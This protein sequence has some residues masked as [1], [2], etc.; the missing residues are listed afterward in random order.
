MPPPFGINDISADTRI[1]ERTLEINGVDQDV[2]R[3]ISKE[4]G[5]SPATFFHAIYGLILAALGRTD[6]VVFGTVMSG[7]QVGDFDYHD[8]VGLFINTIPIRINI[9]NLSIAQFFLTVQDLLIAVT[10]HEQTSLSDIQKQLRLEGDDPLFTSL[11]N[12]RHA[13]E[14]VEAENGAGTGIEIVGTNERTNYPLSFGVSDLGDRFEISIKSDSRVASDK[15]KSYAA[16][17]V[18]EFIRLFQL[19]TS[20]PAMTAILPVPLEELIKPDQLSEIGPAYEEVAEL[21]FCAANYDIVQRFEDSVSRAADKNAIIISGR[22]LTF[23]QL[24]E[25]SSAIAT[26]LKKLGVMSGDRV[27]IL[28]NRHE[29]IPINILA[30]LKLGATYVPVDTKMPAS[31]INFICANAGVKV[32]LTRLEFQ[33]LLDNSSDAAVVLTDSSDTEIVLQNSEETHSFVPEKCGDLGAYIIYT[34][35]STGKPKGVLTTRSNLNYFSFVFQDQ[36]SLLHVEQDDCWLWNSAHTFDASIKGLVCLANGM[37]LVMP[38]D[39]EVGDVDA[40]VGLIKKHD[41]EVFNSLPHV[42]EQVLDGIREDESLTLNFIVSG[43]QV[44]NKLWS[45][46][47]EYSSERNLV[48]INAYGP[49]E[50]T[51]N[52]AFAVITSQNPP[53]IGTPVQGTRCRVIDNEGRTVAK[54]IRGELV[55]FGPGVC[56]GYLDSVEASSASF[57]FNKGRFA[58]YKTGDI[59]SFNNDGYLTFHGRADR[60]VKVRGYRIELT[61]IEL[62][63][64]E[65]TEIIE[66]FVDV[67]QLAEGQRLIVAYI[68]VEKTYQFNRQVIEAHVTKMIPDYMLPNR[69]VTVEKLPRTTTGKVDSRLLRTMG[70]ES[71][72][73][74]SSEVQKVGTVE[75]ELLLVWKEVLGLNSISYNDDFIELGGDSILSMQLVAKAKRKGISITVRDVF[76]NRTIA[77]LAQIGSEVKVNQAYQKK[78]EGGQILLPVQRD[79]LALNS[80][81]DNQFN[82]SVLLK[83]SVNISKSVLA[84]IVTTLIRRHDGLRQKFIKPATGDWESNYHIFTRPDLDQAMEYIDLEGKTNKE[85]ETAIYSIGTRAQGAMDIHNGPMFKAVYFSTGKLAQDR[86]LLI[87]HHLVVD[88]VSWRILIQDIQDYYQISREGGAIKPDPKTCSYQLWAQQLKE[89]VAEGKF[90]DEEKVWEKYLALNVDGIASD[91]APAQVTE[92]SNLQSLSFKLDATSTRALISRGAEFYKAEAHELLIAALVHAIQTLKSFMN[93]R[94]L[95]EGHGRECSIVPSDLSETVGWFTTRYPLTITL[96]DNNLT[97]TVNTAKQACRSIPNGGTGFAALRA[98][99]TDISEAISSAYESCQL[100]FNYLGQFDQFFKDSALLSLDSAQYGSDVG[101]HIQVLQDLNLD[102]IIIDGELDINLRFCPKRYAQEDISTLGNEFVAAL[103]GIVDL[104]TDQEKSMPANISAYISMEELTKICR[105][106]TSDQSLPAVFCTPPISGASLVYGALAEQLKEQMCLYGLQLP[107]LYSDASCDSVENVAAI[108]V[109]IVQFYQESGP[110]RIIGW[111]S[112]GTLAYELARQLKNTGN[113]I[114]FLTILDQP[115]RAPG[116]QFHLYCNDPLFK[117]EGLYKHDLKLDWDAVKLMQQPDAINYIA[118]EIVS[119]GLKP[120]G[121]EDKTIVR[122]LQA[123]VSFPVAMDRYDHPNSDLNINLIRAEQ[124]EDNGKSDLGWREI[125]S[126]QVNIVLSD[127]EHM[128]MV[129]EKHAKCLAKNILRSVVRTTSCVS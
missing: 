57:T 33:H 60:Q 107:S 32:V 67:Q 43:D 109:S 106:L 108:Y 48:A 34:S 23:L 100:Q 76:E 18:S 69:Y 118:S 104:I 113:E 19:D 98:Y 65:L 52:A 96:A 42:V 30:V 83:L 70:A 8:T 116:S 9:A 71:D 74:S 82:Q 29:D 15:L 97:S 89:A 36:L 124:S 22:R 125:T 25:R 94:I 103:E 121:V 55:I 61:E 87:S 47:A 63:L 129:Y 128:D 110:Y 53:N 54:G 4:H 68:V 80:E 50:T 114:E 39:D 35:G 84:K 102:C 5:A 27:A 26:H 56:A 112:G 127:G 115:V 64:T 92:L 10:P 126:G 28:S 85:V 11:L 93:F 59:V 49:T 21:N 51:V 99:S 41:I 62:A 119:Q 123:L 46:L 20:L 101:E 44:S 88:A 24:Q 66:V 79:F 78:V 77:K 1:E 7:R 95:M 3:S 73:L 37:T 12:Y 40:L 117:I 75:H 45:E 120:D 13:S 14:T 17:L 16:G 72:E 38:N 6:D 91:G 58:A 105:P 90:L 111:S 2:I 86:L 122:H 31:R 81:K